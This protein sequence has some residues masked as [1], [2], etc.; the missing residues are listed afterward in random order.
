[1]FTFPTAFL[2]MLIIRKNTEKYFVISWL[3]GAL[4]FY[5]ISIPL[6]LHSLKLAEGIVQ[7]FEYF[8]LLVLPILIIILYSY[9]TRLIEEA[10]MMTFDK[11][12]KRQLEALEWRDPR[13][14][15]ALLWLLFV[16]I[17]FFE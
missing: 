11:K 16:Y 4:M 9:N 14:L 8:D 13:P 7:L 1:M 15:A 12:K 3:W 10:K 2:I 5:G 17:I 6:I